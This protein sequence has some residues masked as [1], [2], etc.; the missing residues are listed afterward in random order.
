MIMEKKDRWLIEK[1][2][3]TN[4]IL[5]TAGD[6]PVTF[7]DISHYHLKENRWRQTSDF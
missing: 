2:P 7:K 6:K 5:K 4:I 1:K 3:K